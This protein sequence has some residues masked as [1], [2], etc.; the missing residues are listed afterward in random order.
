MVDR[1]VHYMDRDIAVLLQKNPMAA[2]QL[3]GI[4]LERLLSEAELRLAT[5]NGV[6]SEGVAEAL[7]SGE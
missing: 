6:P 3:K 5:Q 4:I 7:I 1:E 2:E